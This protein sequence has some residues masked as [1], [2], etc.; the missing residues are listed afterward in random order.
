M[1]YLVPTSFAAFWPS[2]RPPRVKC[3]T[4]SD[5]PMLVRWP[6]SAHLAALA[7]AESL[8]QQVKVIE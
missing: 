6:D 3:I 1:P 2:F 7:N 5:H 4:K 8:E